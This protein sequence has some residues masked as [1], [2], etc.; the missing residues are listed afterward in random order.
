MPN[1]PSS[2]NDDN[3][4]LIRSRLG[5]RLRSSNDRSKLP[6]KATFLRRA[7]HDVTESKVAEESGKELDENRPHQYSCPA[8]LR[9]VTDQMCPAP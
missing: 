8:S 4:N 6:V 5:L 1:G 2:P 9:T 7:V 3:I